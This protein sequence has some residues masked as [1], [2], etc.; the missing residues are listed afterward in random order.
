MSHDPIKERPFSRDSPEPRATT[1]VREEPRNLPPIL[2]NDRSGTPQDAHQKLPSA[3]GAVMRPTPPPSSTPPEQRAARPIGVESLL[4]STSSGNVGSGSHRQYVERADS[5]RTVPSVTSQ[6]DT[7]SLAASST[8]K[9]SV[10]DISL[11]S[12]TPPSISSFPQPARAMTPRSPTSYGPSQITTGIPTATI[13]ARQSPFVS[14]DHGSVILGHSSYPTAP[15]AFPSSYLSSASGMQSPTTRPIGHIGQASRAQPFADSGNSSAHFSASRS[16]SPTSHPQRRSPSANISQP[17]Q[18][19]SFFSGPFAS[20][21]PVLGMPQLGFDKKGPMAGGPPGNGQYPM[22]LDTESGPIPVPIDVQAASKMA[23]EKRKRNATASHR[24]RQR[25]KEKEQETASNIARLEAQVREM[26]EERNF[27][28]QERDILQDVV[29]RNRLPLPARPASPR[30]RRHASMGL[31]GVSQYQDPDTAGRE[32]GR[33]LRRRTSAYVPPQGHLQHVGEPPPPMP[34]HDRI[35]T[36]P[37]EHLQSQQHRM[38]PQG[39]FPPSAHP[40][41]PTAPR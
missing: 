12:I 24:F 27:Y 11:P 19:Q 22:M 10:G 26:T 25:R 35:S 39:S 28:Q 9:S 5:P 34:S 17:G 7:P 16:V 4:N 36:M 33:N 23:D 18:P 40:F 32:E 15:S 38:R 8:R 31:S 2:S 41:D 1:S 20:A 3:H 14:R 30:R 37:S 29:V 13:D 6:P 21:A